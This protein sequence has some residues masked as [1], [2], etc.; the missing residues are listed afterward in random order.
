MNRRNLM[1]GVGLGIAA[2]TLGIA[3]RSD[4]AV[5]STYTKA[6]TG[7]PR[8]KITNVKSILTA[9]QGIRLCVV[10]VEHR[11]CLNKIRSPSD[12]SFQL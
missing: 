10:K 6:T 8:L 1:K 7:L 9:P 3:S 2:G 11:L 5:A 12:F 4:E